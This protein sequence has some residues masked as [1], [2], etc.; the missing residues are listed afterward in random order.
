MMNLSK[1]F[2]QYELRDLIICIFAIALIFSFPN[3]NNFFYYLAAVVMA[4]F[5]HELAHRGVARRLGAL[6]LYRMWPMGLIIGVVF[7]FFRVK[8]V[9]P[10]AVIIYPFRFGRWKHKTAD[11]RG[12]YLSDIEMGLIAFSGIAVNLILAILFRSVFISVD[13]WFVAQTGGLS[14]ALLNAW[15]AFSNLIPFPPLDGS[16]IF[17]WK[18]W[19][20]FLLIFTAVLL[21]IL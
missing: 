1:I 12:G 5:F 4:F 16:K 11:I 7:M 18:P 10:G 20:W 8:F 19:F 3:I 14:I 17:K 13:E 21:F 15:L 6:A 9:A 2:P